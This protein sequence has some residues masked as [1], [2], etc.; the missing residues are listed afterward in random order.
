ML[1][2]TILHSQVSII[3]LHQ[4]CIII[5][6][7]LQFV[8]LFTYKCIC[9]LWLKISIDVPI[10]TTAYFNQIEACNKLLQ[11]SARINKHT[12]CV[13][14]SSYVNILTIS[15]TMLMSTCVCKSVLRTYITWLCKGAVT[16]FFSGFHLGDGWGWLHHP[17]ELI[18]H[19]LNC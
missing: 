14:N 16:L 17:W 5:T 11:T 3:I 18:R 8:S 4:T 13:L 7:S 1:N 6:K 12:Y 9:P 2:T 19:P 10:A 15:S